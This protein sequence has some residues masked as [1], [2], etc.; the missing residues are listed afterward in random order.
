[1]DY[2]HKSPGENLSKSKTK[3][4][5]ARLWID[6]RDR[7]VITYPCANSFR[8]SLAAPIR[9]VKSITLTD[10]RVPIVSGYYYCAL[11]IKNIKDNTLA[12]IKEDGGWPLGTLAI[13]PLVPAEGANGTY[14]YYK[15]SSSKHN[16]GGW[17]VKFPQA[18]GQLSDLQFEV[19]A[20]GGSTGWGGPTKTTILYPIPSEYGQSTSDI[21]K[22][23]LIGLEVKHDCQ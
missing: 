9:A 22:N 10:F 20:W 3:V 21:D 5:K 1:M 19:M 14:T 16:P 7:D 4:N 15:Y 6:S 18:L 11:V 12:P 13:V 23:V 2:H 8:V 17:V